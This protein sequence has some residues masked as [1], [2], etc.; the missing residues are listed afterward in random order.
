MQGNK[1]V[2]GQTYWL[3][4]CMTGSKKQ[5]LKTK[6]S[7]VRECVWFVH[8]SL[9]VFLCVPMMEWNWAFA[10]ISL[11]VVSTTMWLTSYSSYPTGFHEPLLAPYGCQTGLKNVKRDHWWDEKCWLKR[12]LE[13]PNGK[14]LLG[15]SVSTVM[16]LLGVLVLVLLEAVTGSWL[17][18]WRTRL[19]YVG[20]KFMF[21]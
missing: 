15:A 20:R 5:H 18:Q 19:T 16:G 6:C 12:R 2:V 10:S 11:V 13:R 3:V 4:F 9:C 21:A 14:A 17:Q 7:T 8:A 1:S